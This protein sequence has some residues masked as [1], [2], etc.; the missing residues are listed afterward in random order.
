MLE[1]SIH[2]HKFYLNF[3][4]SKFGSVVNFSRYQYL[5]SMVMFAVVSGS[6]AAVAGVGV[7]AVAAVVAVFQNRT[8]LH[9]FGRLSA[10]YLVHESFLLDLDTHIFGD[11]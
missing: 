10:S 3:A 6:A 5:L 8:G 1:F 4:Q 9:S 7:D 2:F 11:L